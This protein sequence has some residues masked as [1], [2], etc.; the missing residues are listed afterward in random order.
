MVELLHYYGLRPK[1]TPFCTGAGAKLLNK[2][3]FVLTIDYRPRQTPASMP[4]L[5]TVSS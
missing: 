2:L 4:S 3:E 5:P 1:T